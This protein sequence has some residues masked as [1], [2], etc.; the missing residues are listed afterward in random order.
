MWLL[1]VPPGLTLGNLTLCPQSVLYVCQNT[2]S[3]GRYYPNVLGQSAKRICVTVTI[4]GHP[5]LP[6]FTSVLFFIASVAS[7]PHVSVTLHVS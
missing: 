5:G 1:Y 7:Y 4:F 6:A 2:K 3:L